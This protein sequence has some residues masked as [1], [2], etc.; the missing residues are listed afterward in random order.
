GTAKKAVPL[1]VNENN[2]DLLVM[3]AHGHHT[4]KDLIFGTTVGAVRHAVKMPVLVV[5]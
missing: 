4:F 1:L 2:V 3:G 5:R